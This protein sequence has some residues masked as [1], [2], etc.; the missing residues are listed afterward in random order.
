MTTAKHLTRQRNEGC[1]TFRNSSSKS[2]VRCAAS[3][4]FKRV[5]RYQGAGSTWKPT[6]DPF[7][8]AG[9]AVPVMSDPCFGVRAT[10]SRHF[11][12]IP[13]G[14][15]MIARVRPRNS[16]ARTGFSPVLPVRSALN[17]P[18]LLG[19]SLQ[20]QSW[21]AW[22]ILLI[23]AMGESLTDDERRIF[24]RLTQTRA[25]TRST[26][27]GINRCNWSAG[28]EVRGTGRTRGLHCG[29]LQAQIIPR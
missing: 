19:K 16:D 28:R 12:N 17:D 29:P 6:G 9:E 15:R 8:R 27:R 24:T 21:R 10:R 20:G 23:A 13:L 2:G 26:G 22:R 11:C 5:P 4:S 18:A 14:I 25:R 1:L 7:Q 3:L